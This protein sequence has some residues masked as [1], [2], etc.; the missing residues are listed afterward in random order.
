[1]ANSYYQVAT[2]PKLYVSYPLFQY[3]N[4][5]LDSYTTDK[6]SFSDDNIIK[7]LQIDPSNQITFPDDVYNYEKF[8]EH[9]HLPLIILE[10]LTFLFHP[11]Y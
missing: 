10:D 7:P 5:A 2:T 6:G 1:M 4:G 3:A 8:F 11:L 9:H